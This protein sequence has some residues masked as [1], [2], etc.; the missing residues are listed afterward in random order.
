[1]KREPSFLFRAFTGSLELPDRKLS[2][3]RPEVVGG[4]T[5]TEKMV[6]CPS[7]RSFD[8]RSGPGIRPSDYQPFAAL[9]P[10]LGIDC[11]CGGGYW[12]M[13]ALH[14]CI[15]VSAFSYF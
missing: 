12:N 11:C 2:E 13:H 14:A 8:G 6:P 7:P 5:L 10:R 9:D 3:V 4:E 1:M 15:N